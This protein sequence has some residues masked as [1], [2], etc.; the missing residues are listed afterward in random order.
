[1][2]ESSKA[3]PHLREVLVR[4][5]QW[6]ED[7]YISTYW[8]TSCHIPIASCCYGDGDETICF[9]VS[10]VI[11]YVVVIIICCCYDTMLSSV[12]GRHSKRSHLSP[13]ERDARITLG[14]DSSMLRAAMQAGGSLTPTSAHSAHTGK[15][16]RRRSHRPHPKPTWY[17][18]PH[19]HYFENG[20]YHRDNYRSDGNYSSE[21]DLNSASEAEYA[22][23]QQYPGGGAGGSRTLPSHLRHSTHKGN[24]RR[25]YYEDSCY[26]GNEDK[27]GHSLD[28]YYSNRDNGRLSSPSSRGRPPDSSPHHALNSPAHY[29][30]DSRNSTREYPSSSTCHYSSTENH[31]AHPDYSNH[32]HPDYKRHYS[33]GD[34]HRHAHGR[35][36]YHSDHDHQSSDRS[37]YSPDWDHCSPERSH[38]SSHYRHHSPPRRHL[39]EGHHHSA[40]E[41]S[42]QQHWTDTS[43]PP[44]TFTPPVPPHANLA[45]PTGDGY[46]TY[47]YPINYQPQALLKVQECERDSNAQYAR[48]RPRH[49]LASPQEERMTSPYDHPRS[50]GKATPT[51]PYKAVPSSS[52]TEGLLESEAEV[53]DDTV[54]PLENN[55]DPQPCRRIIPQQSDTSLGFTPQYTAAPLLQ[56]AGSH[57]QPHPP[58]VSMVPSTQQPVTSAPVSLQVPPPS[59]SIQVANDSHLESGHSLHSSPVMSRTHPPSPLVFN[60]ASMCEDSPWGS[61]GLGADWGLT[62]YL[63]LIITCLHIILVNVSF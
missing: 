28:S 53:A 25:R 22:H 24:D 42:R 27:R 9:L 47:D 54:G 38:S 5:H 3:H 44:P 63:L 58:P 4:Y 46:D 29:R 43:H 39:S 50:S 45:T 31:H 8:A 52:V 19:Y 23:H 57:L 6:R 32:A 11:I 2:P 51:S 56:E 10:I 17:Q 41:D 16:R 7:D 12:L 59:L 48:P 14:L 61:D 35:S 49:L 21:Y 15:R 13:G 40:R 30:Q 37:R 20:R 1:M 18:D 36:R 34:G 60:S 62:V 26:R 55:S 33:Y